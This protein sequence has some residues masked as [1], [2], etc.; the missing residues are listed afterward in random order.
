MID[1]GFVLLCYCVIIIDDLGTIVKRFLCN[2]NFFFFF[3]L[4][5]SYLFFSF[6]FFSFVFHYVYIYLG[7]SV[8]PGY[9]SCRSWCAIQGHSSEPLVLHYSRIWY[10][11]HRHISNLSTYRYCIYIYLIILWNY[12]VVMSPL[13]HCQGGFKYLSWIT[14]YPA[15]GA[16]VY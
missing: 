13:Q 9:D 10:L 4:F 5:F 6:F 11:Q 14:L 1:L 3:F 7:P 15:Y 16:W 2:V 12:N 8:R